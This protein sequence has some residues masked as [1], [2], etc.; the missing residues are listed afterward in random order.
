MSSVKIQLDFLREYYDDGAVVPSSVVDTAFALQSVVKSGLTKSSAYK[1]FIR[2][3]VS[4]RGPVLP[5]D[6]VFSVSVVLNYIENHLADNARLSQELLTQKLC[7][8]CAIYFA[9]RPADLVSIPC[10]DIDKIRDADDNHPASLFMDCKQSRLRSDFLRG[11]YFL[12]RVTFSP[13]EERH[14]LDLVVWY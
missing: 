8:L 11:R 7:T 12:R 3:I 10:P 5:D 13:L 1:D 14:I 6:E 9:A 2:A 4:T